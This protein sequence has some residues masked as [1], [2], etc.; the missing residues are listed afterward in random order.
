MYIFIK[1]TRPST[2][3]VRFIV[4]VTA[5]NVDRLHERAMYNAND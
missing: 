4:F 3:F 2:F 1:L 5:L